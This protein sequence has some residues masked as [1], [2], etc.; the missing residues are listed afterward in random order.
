M[1]IFIAGASGVLGKTIVPLLTE[2]GHQVAGLTRSESGAAIIESM[3]ATAVVCNVFDREPLIKAVVAFAPDVILHELTDL[4]DA[5]EHIAGH[6][7]GNARIRS[8]GTPNLIAAAEAAGKPEFLAQSVAWQMPPGEGADAVA[9][10]ER[11]VLDYR[12][13]VLRYGQL[14]GPGTFYEETVPE[15]PKVE[16]AEA[17]RRTVAAIGHESGIVTVVD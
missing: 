17:G 6:L 10:L 16:I 8:E 14:Y 11:L 15:G 12:G 5:A 7:S 13:V 4:P 1:R 9:T 3:G 2:Q